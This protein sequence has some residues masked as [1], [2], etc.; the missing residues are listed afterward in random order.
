MREAQ[1]V[2]KAKGTSTDAQVKKLENKA[3]DLERAIKNLSKDLDRYWVQMQEALEDEFG[4]R[5][6][7]MGEMKKKDEPF[8]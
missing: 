4:T 6:R 8:F 2:L 5:G 7:E 1:K 3:L